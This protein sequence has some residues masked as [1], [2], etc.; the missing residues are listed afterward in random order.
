MHVSH[1]A[2][3]GEEEAMQ[4]ALV[5]FHASHSFLVRKNKERVEAIGTE[6]SGGGGAG[7]GTGMGSVSSS[8]SGGGGAGVGVQDADTWLSLRRYRKCNMSV[9]ELTNK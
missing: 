2:I 6:I 7:S 3:A 4:A 8:G 9:S 5:S 1:E